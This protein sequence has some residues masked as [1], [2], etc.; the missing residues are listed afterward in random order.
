MVEKANTMNSRNNIIAAIFQKAW[1]FVFLVIIVAFFSIFGKGF[2]G[3]ENFQNIMLTS[4]IL[5]LVGIGQ[6]FVMI[7]GGIDLSVAYTTGLSTVIAALIM[8]NMSIAGFNTILTII[9]GIVAAIVVCS[10]IP[11]LLNGLIITRFNLPPL[12]VTLGTYLAIRGIGLI[13]SNGYP[14][15]KQPSLVGRI[16][17]GYLL[18]FLPGKGLYWGVSPEI[19][20]ELKKNIIQI[21]PYPLILVIIILVVTHFILSR[22]QFGLY[23]YIIGGNAEAARRAGINVRSYLIKVYVLCAVLAAIAG[24]VYTFRFGSG[25][26]N[27]G[28]PRLFDAVA[29]VVIGG[30]SVQGGYGRIIPGTFVGALIV[31]V[32]QTGLVSMGVSPYYQFIAIGFV[33]ILAVVIDKSSPWLRVKR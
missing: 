20:S 6:T 22:T 27:A 19:S 21:L 26:A 28:E 17:N 10:I 13:L 14:I 1:S 3:F 23:I 2:F 24:L 33:I 4:C 31:A 25:N 29:A 30:T 18:Y 12:I 16:G 32:I 15:G 11:G 7:T 8:K 5:L 9:I